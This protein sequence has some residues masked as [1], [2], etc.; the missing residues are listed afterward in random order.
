M[1]CEAQCVSRYLEQKYSNGMDAARTTGNRKH[2][3]GRPGVITPAVV[4]K[5]AEVF[6]LDVT[7][8]EAL[9][10]AEVSRDAYYRKVRSDESFRTKMEQA[11]QYATLVARQTVIRQI[12]EDGDL[13]LKY[14]ERKRKAEF[15]PRSEHHVSDLTL[16]EIV[17]KRAQTAKRV[18][19]ENPN[20]DA[21][22]SQGVSRWSDSPDDL[23]Q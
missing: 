7:V 15:S 17:A 14:L 5:L 23:A 8:E 12:Q 2:A 10:H 19:W 3:G 21:I 9:V 16:A 6:K 22:D 1:D 11:R 4:A 13:A 18:D 20:L